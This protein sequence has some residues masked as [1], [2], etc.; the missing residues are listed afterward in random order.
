MS[1]IL[2]GTRIDDIVVL[3]VAYPSTRCCAS[4]SLPILVLV[5]AMKVPDRVMRSYSH[6]I[7]VLLGINR[8]AH[9]QPYRSTTGTQVQSERG[10]R[11]TA[12]RHT[13]GVRLLPR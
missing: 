12:E 13:T 4:W 9:F 1:S 7:L 11:R 3:V 8:H 2:V 6:P 10:G 5:V